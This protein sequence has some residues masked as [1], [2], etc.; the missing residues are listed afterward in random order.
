MTFPG[1]RLPDSAWA[2]LSAAAWPLKTGTKREPEEEAGLRSGKSRGDSPVYLAPWGGIRPG[3]CAAP[4]NALTKREQ[5]ADACEAPSTGSQPAQVVW[6]ESLD[7]RRR[8]CPTGVLLTRRLGTLLGAQLGK[9][10]EAKRAWATASEAAL[11]RWLGEVRTTSNGRRRRCDSSDWSRAPRGFPTAWTRRSETAGY[12]LIAENG[13]P[14]WTWLQKQV[15]EDNVLNA[16]LE[17]GN[18]PSTAGPA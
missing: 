13:L 1:R 3:A 12:R 4:R 18:P 2:R 5:H 8:P 17:L 16:S 6:L 14:P 7:H 10:H 15:D 9:T 11:R